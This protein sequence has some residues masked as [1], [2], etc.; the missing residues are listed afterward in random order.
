M[1]LNYFLYTFLC[2]QVVLDEVEVDKEQ[3]PK[4]HADLSFGDINYL[5]DMKT[6]RLYNTDDMIFGYSSLFMSD[7]YSMRFIYLYLF[8]FLYHYGNNLDKYF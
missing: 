5:N 4:W 6:R 7:G 8:W 2:P 3:I 1:S